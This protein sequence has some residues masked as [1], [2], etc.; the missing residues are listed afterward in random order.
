MQFGFNGYY[1]RI[2]YYHIDNSIDFNIMD[3]KGSVKYKYGEDRKYRRAGKL[4]E[5]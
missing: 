2:R 4:Y 5:I 1:M 3:Y